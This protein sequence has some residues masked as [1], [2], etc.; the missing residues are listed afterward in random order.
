MRTELEIDVTDGTKISLSLEDEQVAEIEKTD[1]RYSIL[2]ESSSP[3]E[4]VE[5]IDHAQG[6]K[7]EPKSLRDIIDELEEELDRNPTTEHIRERLEEIGQEDR[8]EDLEE[9]L[10]RL[11]KQG[12][13]MNSDGWATV[14]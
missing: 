1:S 11:W 8:F 10:E 5:D 3:E 9:T 14:L 4:D 13:V 6:E 12:E 2:I 7:T